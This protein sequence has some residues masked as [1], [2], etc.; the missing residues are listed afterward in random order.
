MERIPLPPAAEIFNLSQL[1]ERHPR[2]LP[3]SRLQWAARNR[4][5]NGLQAANA[6]FESPAGELLFHEP[7][8]I[9]WL[10]GLVGRKKPRASRSRAA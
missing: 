10:L 3:K 8:T 9:A 4:R 1:A 5:K 2:L 6:V 7:A